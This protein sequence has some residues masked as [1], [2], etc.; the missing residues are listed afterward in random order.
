[1]IYALNQNGQ[2]VH[3]RDALKKEN[4]YCEFCQDQMRPHQGQF[5][6]WHFEHTTNNNCEEI[7]KNKGLGCVLPINK[8]PQMCKSQKGCGLYEMGQCL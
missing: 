5:M 4:Y 6:P 8:D 7:K 1:M 2:T 3:V